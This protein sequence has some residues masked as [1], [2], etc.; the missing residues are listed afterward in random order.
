MSKHQIIL[1]LINNIRDS[2]SE[3][4][5][6]FL[7]GSCL[8]FF[9]ILKTV[10]P[11]AE[12]YFNI[13]HIIT[14]IDNRYYDITGSVNPEGYTPYTQFYNKKRTSRSFTRMLKAEYP[15]MSKI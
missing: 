5:N 4:P 6:I 13:D 11:E 2:H 7:Y 1:N 14:K 8:N 3:M 12:A 9:L 15:L 10:Y